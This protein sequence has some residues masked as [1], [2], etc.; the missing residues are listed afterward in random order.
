MGWVGAGGVGGGVTAG[1][2]GRVGGLRWEKPGW[3]DM[4]IAVRTAREPTTEKVLLNKI[5]GTRL[6]K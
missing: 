3:T 5:L 2:V 1:G 6:L 4:A